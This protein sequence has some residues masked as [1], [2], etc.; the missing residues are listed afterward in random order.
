MRRPVHQAGPIH[1][2]GKE[3]NR[4][5]DVQAGLVGQSSDVTTE[6]PTE[7]TAWLRASVLPPLKRCSGRQ[8]AKLLN[9]DRRTVD[10][11]RQGRT[12]QARHVQAVIALAVTE[13]RNSLQKS[14]EPLPPWTS[15]EAVL[16]AWS[17][18]NA[19]R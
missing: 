5:D 13:A 4:L 9:I 7:S 16:A 10:R 14:G 15:N 12:P 11:I 2:I 18:Q 1:H 3:A 6:Y 19:A 8:L 17:D